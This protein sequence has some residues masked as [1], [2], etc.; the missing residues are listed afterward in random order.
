MRPLG[1]SRRREKYNIKQDHK[2]VDS[3]Y[4]AEDRGH[5]QSVVSTVIN[6]EVP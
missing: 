6:F 3:V 4:R 5:W 1:R 2:A